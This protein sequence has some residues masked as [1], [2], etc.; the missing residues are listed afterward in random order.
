MRYL[1]PLCLI[2]PLA[3]A[4]AAFFRPTPYD[5]FGLLVTSVALNPLP[6]RISLWINQTIDLP[7]IRLVH[8]CSM[9]MLGILVTTLSR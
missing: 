9:E 6:E 3:L 2:T 7:R 5:R 8:H 4:S 1:F